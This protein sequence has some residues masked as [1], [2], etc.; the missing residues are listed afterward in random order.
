MPV[1]DKNDRLEAQI[2]KLERSGPK[3]VIDMDASVENTM[4]V[5][6]AIEEL[7]KGTEAGWKKLAVPLEQVIEAN[8]ASNVGLKKRDMQLSCRE[9]IMDSRVAANRVKVDNLYTK[10]T[11]GVL[12]ALVESSHPSSRLTS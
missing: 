2:R 12:D 4:V 3:E 7:C 5:F 11:L 6:S 8:N 9:D 10:V 1:R